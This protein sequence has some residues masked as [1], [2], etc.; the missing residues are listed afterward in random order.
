ML[1]VALSSSTGRA[2]GT[3]VHVVVTPPDRLAAASQAVDAVIADIDAACSRF[4]DESEIMRL[5]ARAGE[6]VPISPLLFAAL[7]AAIRGAELSGGSVD[8][9]VGTAVK[10]I[11]YVGDF[12]SVAPDGGPVSL[13]IDSAP[14][15]RCVRLDE[16]THSALIPAGVEIDLGA[17]A[18]ALASDLAAAAARRAMGKGGVLVNLGGDIAVAGESPKD[19]WVIQI[20]EASDAPL[21]AES[22]AIAI[23]DGGVATSSTTIRRWRRGGVQLH[24]IVDPGTGVPAAGPWRT[25]TC[26]AG[27]CLDANI[28]AT[29]AI[30]RGSEAVA[31]LTERDV[32]ARLISDRSEVVRTRAWP[33]P[34]DVRGVSGRARKMPRAGRTVARTDRSTPPDRMPRPASV[35]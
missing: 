27:S 13:R 11:G 8:P 30:V 16:V 3:S 15:W 25:V 26:A 32:P 31:W 35:A 21:T 29:A 17:T 6:W 1:P 2:L 33:L 14:G 10:T 23:R 4:R 18:K 22:E 12:A 20:A 24:H 34:L 28:A 19:G 9:T 5:Q 7:R